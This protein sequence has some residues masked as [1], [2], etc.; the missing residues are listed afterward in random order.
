MAQT[1]RRPELQVPS[2]ETPAPR[3]ARVAPEDPRFA[4][5]QTLERPEMIR[6][7]VAAGRVR[8][9]NAE[10]APGLIG[11]RGSRRTAPEVALSTKVP[12]YVLRQLR[13]RYAESGVTIRNQVLFALRL[14]GVEVR[15]EDITDERRRPR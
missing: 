14:A 5:A 13:R 11:P 3:P 9:I 12:D 6:E 4:L 8:A 7:A 15:D 2:V 1:P 10:T